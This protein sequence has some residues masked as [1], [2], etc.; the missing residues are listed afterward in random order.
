[1]DSGNLIWPAGNR[2]HCFLSTKNKRLTTNDDGGVNCKIYYSLH[3]VANTTK[4]YSMLFGGFGDG[5]VLN[6]NRP[7][8]YRK[9]RILKE[10]FQG[11]KILKVRC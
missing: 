8:I 6:L 2:Y 1:M 10:R 11:R 3:M 4:K 5:A 9:I 7:K